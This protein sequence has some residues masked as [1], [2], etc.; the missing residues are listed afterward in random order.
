MDQ[1]HIPFMRNGEL[2]VHC[3]R[4]SSGDDAPKLSEAALDPY[5][6][7]QKIQIF[8]CHVLRRDIP[9]QFSEKLPP[10]ETIY[11]YCINKQ[12][13]GEEYKTVDPP[14][15]MRSYTSQHAFKRDITDRGY[16]E[17]YLFK[18]VNG[19][20]LPITFED[21]TYAYKC[22]KFPKNWRDVLGNGDPLRPA[23]K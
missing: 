23:D 2:S 10:T 12:G 9:N 6:L 7:Q 19:Y 8:A 15:P 17:I 14:G 16:Y 5:E 3:L 18:I 22:D 1:L 21:Y 4:I 20:V 11:Y 13:W